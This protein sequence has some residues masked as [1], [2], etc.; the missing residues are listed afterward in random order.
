RESLLASMSPEAF[1]ALVA[2]HATVRERLL[3]RLAGSVRELTARLLDF[4]AR[5]VQARVWAE[6]LRV[7]RAAGVEG[8]AARIERAPTHKEMASR[9]GTSREEVTRELSRLARQGLLERSGRVLVL[10]DVRALETLVADVAPEEAEAPLDAPDESREFV[11]PG[12][13]RQ[14]RAILVADVLDSSSLMERD[15]DRTLERWRALFAHATSDVIPSHAGRSMAK[16]LG[17]GFL[18]EFPDA[19]H[20]VKCAFELHQG[21]ARLN[22]AATAPAL[23]MRVGIH[24]ADVIV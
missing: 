11:A 16:L 4:G 19:P 6:L 22:A 3:R 7:A 10:R 23:G 21:L 14:R 9:V 15:E 1:R 20:A 8:N 13:S 18:A 2:S 17:D 5:R 24:V 12:A